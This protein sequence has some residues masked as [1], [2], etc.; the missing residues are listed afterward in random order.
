[1]KVRSKR[2]GQALLVAVAVVLALLPGSPAHADAI[3]V[4][5]N[6]PGSNW[7]CSAEYKSPN[8]N[9]WARSCVIISGASA[10]PA[11]LVRNASGRT[12]T[13]LPGP[14]RITLLNTT[15]ESVITSSRCGGVTIYNGKKKVC[16]ER[17]Y[18]LARCTYVGAN[19]YEF[20]YNLPIPG[21]TI[22]PARSP[23]PRT[24]C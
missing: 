23:A 24:A 14:F 15:T 19:A 17:S 3:W 2:F 6:G 8:H 13:S 22:D 11:L 12:L 18:T 21:G 16:T 20:H 1:M 9:V 4:D 7:W 10:R 5:T